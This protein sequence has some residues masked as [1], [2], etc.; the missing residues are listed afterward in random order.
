MLRIVL[1][2]LVAMGFAT[3]VR[4]ESAADLAN[5]LLAWAKKDGAKSDGSEFLADALKTKY[6]AAQQ[7]KAANPHA[8]E[9]FPALD[10]RMWGAHNEKKKAT[11]KVSSQ[12]ED[13]EAE[14]CLRYG[15]G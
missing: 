8:C 12:S 2:V 3:T 9:N 4:A 13:E 11:T 7:T 6:L 14:G 5:A 10:E 15:G 1:I